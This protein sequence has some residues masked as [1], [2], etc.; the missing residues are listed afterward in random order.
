MTLFAPIES[1]NIPSL[2]DQGV[3]ESEILKV[4]IRVAQKFTP[5][6]QRAAPVDTG[7][8]KRSLRVE[9]LPDNSGVAL[10]S[11]VFYAG[12]VEYGTK[13]MR[14]RSYA[15]SVVPD[16]ISYMNDLLSELGSVSRQGVRVA[17]SGEQSGLTSARVS[18]QFISNI[19]TRPRATP[20]LSVP[21]EL[22]TQ[23]G[24]SEGQVSDSFVQ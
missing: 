18:D 1:A 23:F 4:L 13:R 21:P 22:V 16:L 6:L 19:R 20:S 12:F 5:I 14:P 10:T 15:E 24:V 3:P 8:L 11:P 17:A 9:L 7:R 2:R